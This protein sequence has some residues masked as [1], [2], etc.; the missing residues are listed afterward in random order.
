MYTLNWVSTIHGEVQAQQK[1]QST[2]DFD[3]GGQGQEE[4][5]GRH[6][7]RRHH[8]SFRGPVGNL[9]QTTQDEDDAQE[10][11]SNQ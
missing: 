7:M 5:N 10:D 8:I 6:S 9:H 3:D 2:S 11:P 4:G 1:S